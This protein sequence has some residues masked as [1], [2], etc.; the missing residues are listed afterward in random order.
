VTQSQLLVDL[1]T[2]DIA[3]SA[4]AQAFLDALRKH[5]PC[6]KHLFA[7][8]AYDSRQLLDKAAFLNFTV[9]IVKRTQAAFVVLP[10]RWVSREPSAG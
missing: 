4:G 7:D 3:D 1:T 6:I 10:R 2:A 9:E 5:W 8:G